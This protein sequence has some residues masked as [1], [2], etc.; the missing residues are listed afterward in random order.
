MNDGPVETQ[1]RRLPMW[2]TAKA[3]Y[4]ALFRNAGLALRLAIVPYVLGFLPLL[5]LT[6]FTSGSTLADAAVLTEL[7]VSGFVLFYLS[8]LISALAVIPMITA[9]HR[10]VLLGHGH[11]DARLSYSVDRT[12]W[13]YLLKLILYFLVVF[14]IS[15]AL[16]FAMFVGLSGIEVLTQSSSSYFG[17]ITVVGISVLMIAGYIYYVGLVL[18]LCMVFPAAAIGAQLGFAEAWRLTRGNTWRLVAVFLVVLIPVTAGSIVVSL[19]TLGTAYFD[20]NADV[21]PGLGSQFLQVVLNLPFWIVG[22]C[23]S[24]SIWSWS[25]RYLVENADITLPGERA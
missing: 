17:T 1:T 20:P 13:T 3:S 16:F 22:L 18:R 8:S 24:T 12:E 4:M 15:L 19:V 21:M 14:L 11:S 6:Y 5:V 9:W 23:A 7:G 10:L 2:R 25:Y